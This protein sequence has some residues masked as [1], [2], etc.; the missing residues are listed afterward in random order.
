MKHW[1]NVVVWCVVLLIMSVTVFPVYWVV[2]TSL[3][4]PVEQ[5]TYPPPL[6]PSTFTLE[7]YHVAISEQHFLKFF[8]NSLVITLGTVGLSVSTGTLAG[9]AFSRW[10]FPGSKPLLFW[11]LMTRMI[12]PITIALPFYILMRGIHLVDTHVALIL[13]YTSFNLP[14]TMWL[15]TGY[16]QG[17][18]R[19]LDDA[20]RVDGC[21]YLGAFRRVLLPVAIPGISA[22]IVIAALT[23]WNEYLFAL[24]LAPGNAKTMP[25]AVASLITDRVINWGVMASGS[26]ICLVP[27]I[28]L[29][30]ILQKF[31]V[32]GMTLGAVKG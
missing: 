12:P 24:I 32:R 4:L 19:E 20:A 1:Y 6:V 3:K 8:L 29:S 13:A 5:Y 9:Y 10:V 14:F 2:I 7:S 23:A 27:I 30:V 28:A 22:A 18:P 16:F 31:L 17:I 21:S 11:V 26:V 25:V 15:M